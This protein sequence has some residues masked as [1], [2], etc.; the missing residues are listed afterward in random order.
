MIRSS[1]SD[2]GLVKHGSI[3]TTVSMISRL[4]DVSMYLGV[5]AVGINI[6]AHLGIF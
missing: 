2:V 5:D 6:D 3:L 4:V 1:M